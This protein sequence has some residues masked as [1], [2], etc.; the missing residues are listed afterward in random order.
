MNNITW[1]WGLFKLLNFDGG[2]VID[3]AMIAISGTKM[4]IPLYA[5]IIY[6]VWRHYGWRGAI[7]F[8][9]AAGI[10]L[11]LADI[12]AGIFKHSGPLKDLWPDFPVRLRPMFNE[13]L[14]DTHFITT[15][16]DQYGT[17]SAHAATV[18][19]LTVLTSKIIQR[20]WYTWLIACVAI[21]ICYSRI[22]L[23]CHFPQDIIIGAIL[24]IASGFIGVLIFNQILRL[25]QKI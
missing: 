16:H 11:G 24:G 17:V 8:I 10:A 9:I 22:Y 5:L 23:A 7:T 12:V 18:I 2:P 14:N 19:A 13:Q 1:D 3:T 15:G 25:L 6:L 4:W 21:L 20:K